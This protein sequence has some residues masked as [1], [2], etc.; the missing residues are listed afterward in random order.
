MPA[1]CLLYKTWQKIKIT[2]TEFQEG[3]G[4]DG[5]EER[6][7]QEE[8]GRRREAGQSKSRI[9]REEDWRKLK[10]GLRRKLNKLKARKHVQLQIN[11][12]QDTCSLLY[13]LCRLLDTF[14]CH[15]VNNSQNMRSAF[16]L[17]IKPTFSYNTHF[18]FP[19]SL[20]P[21]S[22]LSTSFYPTIKLTFAWSLLVLLGKS[23]SR[24]VWICLAPCSSNTGIMVPL[25]W[26][27]MLELNL[28]ME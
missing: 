18:F 3:A 11:S 6:E 16:I 1:D 17:K 23:D 5:E 2:V 26:C 19:L 24:K 13:S 25:M 21:F 28:E 22:P 9:S 15:G 10:Y 12:K 14:I 20:S 4:G 27:K 7:E 8:M